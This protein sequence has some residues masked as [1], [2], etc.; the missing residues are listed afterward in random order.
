M[1]AVEN[2]DTVLEE[3]L[4]RYEVKLKKRNVKDPK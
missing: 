3:F 1:I 2:L 4:H